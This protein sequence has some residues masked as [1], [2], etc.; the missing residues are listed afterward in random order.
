MKKDMDLA[1]RIRG[2]A[3]RDHRD[4]MNS[5]EHFEMLPYTNKRK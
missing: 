3:M 5:G 4:T 2:D 1:R